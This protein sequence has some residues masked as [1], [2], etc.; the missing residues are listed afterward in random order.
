M[1][2]YVYLPS[3]S[4]GVSDLLGSLVIYLV[5]VPH[6]RIFFPIHCCSYFLVLIIVLMCFRPW[7]AGISLAWLVNLR[8]LFLLM[9]LFY[10][11]VSKH[12]ISF[13]LYRKTK[14]GPDMMKL[15]RKDDFLVWRHHAQ[16]SNAYLDIYLAFCLFPRP[17][18]YNYP[19]HV[20]STSLFQ[21][22]GSTDSD[23]ALL[24][25]TACKAQN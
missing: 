12:K 2:E 1:H 3:R 9:I 13:F 14:S 19:I 15:G 18:S 20:C 4:S 17:L 25:Q 16:L 24:L 21:L 23:V 8:V 5:P 6:F 22:L 7:Y 10:L 11:T